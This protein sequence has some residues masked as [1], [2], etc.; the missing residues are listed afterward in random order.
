MSP[1]SRMSHHILNERV[2]THIPRQI[3]NDYAD[4]GGYNLTGHLIYEQMMVFVLYDLLYK[5]AGYN[6][7]DKTA[8]IQ[9]LK[10]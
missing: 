7:T 6:S 8:F 9:W 1:E 3:W 10:E 5:H 2:R 4:T